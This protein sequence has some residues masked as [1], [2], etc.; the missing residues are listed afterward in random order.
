VCQPSQD[1]SLHF[2]S[3]FILSLSS[4][5]HSRVPSALQSLMTSL[6]TF[7][8]WFI[9]RTRCVLS[10][11]RGFNLGRPGD[12]VEKIMRISVR[13]WVSRR[14]RKSAE[15]EEDKLGVRTYVFGLG[16]DS[17]PRKRRG[18]CQACLSRGLRYRLVFTILA[19]LQPISSSKEEGT[20]LAWPV[21]RSSAVRNY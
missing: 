21:A 8:G 9:S 15:Q 19:A 10:R 14:K 13:R 3:S 11:V 18:A 16:S 7:P 6:L 12:E 20:N 4:R 17:G 2:L 1:A 5:T